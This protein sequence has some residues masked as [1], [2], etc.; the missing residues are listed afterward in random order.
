MHLIP[1]YLVNNRIEI[2]ANEAGYITEYKPVYQRH[3]TVYRG[4]DNVLQFKLIN[5]DQKPINTSL[6]T[7][8]FVAFDENDNM[9]I[10]KDCTTLDDGS[11]T[12][13]GLFQVTV[14]ENELYSYCTSFS[15]LKNTNNSY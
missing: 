2:L 14:S 6:Y 11:S 8:R 1:R 5:P 15:Q 13:R 10:D 7:P 12:S 3:I 9:V 4:I